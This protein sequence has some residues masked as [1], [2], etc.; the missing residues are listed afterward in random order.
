MNDVRVS[1]TGLE[2]ARTA[3]E[4]LVDDLR[5]A[6]ETNGS[7]TWVIAGGTSPNAA[8]KILTAEYVNALDW[9]RVWIII[10]DERIVPLED[11]D[12]NWSV[13]KALLLDHLSIPA[14]RL[15]RPISDRDAEEAAQDYARRLSGLPETS[16]GVPRLDVVWLGM[17]EDGHTLSLFPDHPSSAPTDDIVIPVHNSPKPPPDRISLTFKALTGAAAGYILAAG[18][19]KADVIMRARRGDLSLPI[20]R[21]AE[22][23]TKAGGN[24]KWLLDEAAASKL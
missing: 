17:G 16:A 3:A 7:A 8:Y 9:S 10:G 13:A 15:I 2:L 24:V 14:E 1:G 22:V 12:S 5:L 18:A 4:L 23:I 19:G 20:A 11:P 21:A 6:I